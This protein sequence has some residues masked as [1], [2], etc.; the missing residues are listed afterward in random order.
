MDGR[1]EGGRKEIIMER[2]N[3]GNEEG[4]I[5]RRK[6]GRKEGNKKKKRRK[7]S[8][9]RGRNEKG[10]KQASKEIIHEGRSEEWTGKKFVI[11]N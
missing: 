6:G 3:E 8:T 1:K 9:N 10:P 11:F 4:M 7:E 5:E 2:R